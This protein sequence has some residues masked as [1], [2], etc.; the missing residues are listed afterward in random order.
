MS[1]PID[2]FL[3]RVGGPRRSGGSSQWSCLCPAHPDRRRSLAL[4]SDEDNIVR[5]FCHAGCDVGD[6]LTAMGLTARDFY[7]RRKRQ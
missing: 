1:Q 7:P 4:S 5:I 3:E 6:I 2:K